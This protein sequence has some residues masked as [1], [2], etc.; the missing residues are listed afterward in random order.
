MNRFDI[1]NKAEGDEES[2]TL[3]ST[4]RP[5]RTQHS[6]YQQ[7]ACESVGVL[8]LTATIAMKADALGIGA[9]LAVMIFALGHISGAPKSSRDLGSRDPRQDW[10]VTCCT[11]H[12]CTKLPVL[13]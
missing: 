5:T 7:M 6:V 3:L 9:M 4:V 8:F 12:G 11:L 1:V 13:S 10:L 2:A